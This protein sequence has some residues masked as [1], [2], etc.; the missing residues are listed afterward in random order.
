VFY[1]FDLLRH[2]GEDL[3]KAPLI[4]RKQRLR[5][6]VLNSGCNELIYAQ[7]IETQGVAF[8]EEICQRDFEGIVAKRRLSFY[9]NNGTGW[10]KI[11]NPKYSQAEGR[12]ELLKRT[13]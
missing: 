13:K 7:H 8:F 3:R 1:A 12:H 2:D 10:L 5:E 11:K 9:K 6:L 4:E